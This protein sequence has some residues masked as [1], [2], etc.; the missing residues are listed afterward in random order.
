MFKKTQK[1]VSKT[2]LKQKFPVDLKTKKQGDFVIKSILSGEDKRLLCIVGPCSIDSEKSVFL[3][4][5]KLKSLH[6]LTKDKLFIV[7][8]LHTLK[9]R[10]RDG[11]KGLIFNQTKEGFDEKINAEIRNLDQAKALN[12]DQFKIQSFDQDINSGLTLCRKIFVSAINDFGFCPSDELL[13]IDL[14]DFFDDCISHYTIGARTALSS[15]HRYLASGLSAP[16][17][18]KNP[19]NGDID[20]LLDSVFVAQSPNVFAQNGHQIQS[21]GNPFAHAIFRGFVDTQGDHHSNIT[22]SHIEKFIKNQTQKGLKNVPLIIDLSHSNSQKDFA[23]QPK[24]LQ[25]V[26]SLFKNKDAKQSIKG[27]MAESFLFDGRSDTPQFGYSLTD[28]CMGFEL[29]K[30]TILDFCDKI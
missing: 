27:I 5:E 28:S 22:Q 17:G 24:N 10:S 7:P 4:L 14:Y 26:A 11:F 23:I 25:A 18:F 16:T 20:A 30:K 6:E 3:Y 19:I 12:I 15:Q 29:T 13:F 8:R 1:L 2:Q 9:P 21:F